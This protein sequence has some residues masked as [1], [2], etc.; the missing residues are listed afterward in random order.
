MKRQGQIVS[1]AIQNFEA[2]EKAMDDMANS[3]GSAE[4]EMAIIMDSVD[5]KAN[6]LKETGVGIAQNLFKSEDMKSILDSLTKLAET[7]DWVTEKA[8]LFG[9]IGLGTGIVAGFKALSGFK[10][11]LP[12]LVGTINKIKGL[13]FSTAGVDAYVASL[14]GL[15]ATQAEVALSS[16][17]LDKA[18]KQQILNK[19]AETSAT[20]SLTSAEATEA[21]TRSLGSQKAA[22]ELLI[23]SGLVTEEQLLA[24]ATIEVTAAELEKAVASGI[25]TAQEKEQI[26]TA[27]G[28]TRTNIGL[29]ASFKLLATSIW[30]SI[31]AMATWLVTNPMGWLTLA[32][33]GVTALC[34]VY[35]NLLGKRKKLAE[36]KIKTL[37][38]DISKIDEEISSLES[39][40]AK[41]EDAKGDK[42]KLA[43]IQAELNDA[44]GDTPGLLNAE[45][46]AYEI[47]N[48]KL[49]ANIELQKQQR[50][51][52]QQDKV[53]ANAD[54]FYNN[55]LKLTGLLGIDALNPDLS[56]GE[57]RRH[58]RSMTSL[59]VT[60]EEYVALTGI[61]GRQDFSIEQW[62]DY[63]DKQVDIAYQVFE[64]TIDSYEGDGGKDFIKNFI[65]YVVKRGGSLEEVSLALKTVI[66]NQ[67]M[68]DAINKYWESLVDPN[69]NSEKALKSVKK[70]IDDIVAKNPNLKEFF[71]NYYKEIISS[72]KVI[73]DTNKNIKKT[74]VSISDLESASDKINKLS[75]AFKELS[76]DGY[77]TTKTIG[78]IQTATGLTG[79][80]W[81]EYQAKLLSAK[82]GTSEFN[83]IMSELTHRILD[84]AFANRDLTTLTE[85]EIAAMLRENGVVNADAVAH[86]WLTSTKI[87]NMLA[88]F[89]Y[90]NATEDELKILLEE[91]GVLGLTETAVGNLSKAYAEA[92]AAMLKAATTGALNRLKISQD[93]LKG[94]KTVADA[95][96][97]MAGKSYDVN[98]DGVGDYYGSEK[99]RSSFDKYRDQYNADVESVVGI[100]KAQEE[101]D[102]LIN[103]I[104]GTTPKVNYTNDSSK[105]DK[106]KPDYE[107]PTEAVINR[108]N[109]RANELEQQEEYIQNAIEI[110]EIEKD[111]EK[112][113]LLTNDLIDGRK[114]RVDALKT[115]NAELYQ[116]AEDLQNSTSQWN[117][118]EWFDS[119]GNATEAYVALYNGSTKEV[120]EQLEEQF[121]KISKIK[122]ALVENDEELVGL[123]EELFQDVET[124]SDL[125]SALH[126]NRVRD[127][128]HERDI[129]LEQNPYHDT[130]SYYKLLQ[131]EYHKEAE[132]LRALDSE[133]YKEEIQE[134]QLQWWDAQNAIEDWDWE[135]S[136][137]WIEERNTYNDWSKYGDSEV[138]A[139]ERVLER[140][141]NATIK[142][143]EKIKEAEKNLFEARKKV[144]DD[145]LNEIKSETEETYDIRINRLDSES[146]LLS[147]HFEL[148]NSIAEEQHNLNK[149]LLEAETIGAK[150]N[151]HER[152]SLLTRS[153]YNK[154]SDKLGD[155]MVD[156][157]DLQGDYMRDLKSATKDTIEEVTNQYER[158]YELKMKEYE[159]VKAELNLIKA[160]QKLENTENEK[161]VRTWNGSGWTYEAKLQDVLNAQ[162]E[163]ENAKYDLA[164]SKTEESQQKALNAI[165]AEADALQTE[166]NRLVSAIEDMAE[167]MEDSGK[168]I[169]SMLKTIAETDLPTFDAIIQTM[170]DSIKNAFD[171]SDEEIDGIR[172]EYSITSGQL[173]DKMKQNSASWHEAT[174][175][176]ERD[177]LVEKNAEIADILGLE[178]EES[179]GRWKKPDGT[180]AYARGTKNANS[181]LGLFD[182]DGFGSELI[183]TDNGILTQFNGGERVFTS[184]MADRLWEFSKNN[185][186]FNLIQPNII[187]SIPIEDRINNVINNISN[188][189][190]DTY[191]IKD[192]QLNESEGGTLKGF[193]DFLKKKV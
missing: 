23:K 109:L 132:R 76:S 100:A 25:I 91:V 119:Q 186:L 160:Q 144:F 192:V 28:L 63:W 127:I 170:S 64:D 58:A 19:L 193:I 102:K 158:Q 150:M 54:L 86:D 114:K 101:I 73:A 30:A 41:L 22:E 80:R 139:W 47:A 159:I 31:K 171:I 175:K 53:K 5:Y 14:R 154:L 62:R 61:D 38:E 130:I 133:K 67:D 50:K 40:Q 118:E 172:N 149:E 146:S 57:M 82:A 3:A 98:G 17:G 122:D 135:N 34:G 6:K 44:I 33:A 83:Q 88:T 121:E 48:A 187:K 2:A 153:E 184:D 156:I 94:I 84:N 120:Q 93:E 129:T 117:E 71:D 126:E 7:L 45:G 92:Q 52:L 141:N 12:M 9:T 72:G 112:Q 107:D 43:Q 74:A 115:A 49:K 113:I 16:A 151:E 60:A 152:E 168:N 136:S 137:R 55:P 162:E 39:L 90:A 145:L 95:Y 189:F 89:D 68:Q 85:K 147:K 177:S 116:M 15:S 157:T 24:G 27:L 108:I 169:T 183:L 42:S 142:D 51:Q 111:Y 11:S 190:G 96:K 155:I 35:D 163:V 143:L 29:G 32:I 124:L 138:K 166:K 140:L 148:V 65:S 21:L 179:T 165:D 37:N 131:D 105:S 70:V 182:E 173:L 66:D 99:D 178:Y 59:G 176:D 97:L 188:A 167:K 69:I 104:G 180:Y 1:A 161:S 36:E 181:G 123:N 8:G 46:K 79:S 75:S 10:S 77:I 185:S 106:N 20:V 164:K 26:A 56:A 174:T 4:R 13:T 125:Y 78:E 87:K 18:Q 110:A 134:L 128:E 103:S 81:E 191:M